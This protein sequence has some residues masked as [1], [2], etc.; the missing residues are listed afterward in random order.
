MKKRKDAWT[1]AEDKKLSILVQDS[2]RKGY[3]KSQAFQDASTLV[4]RTPAACR[5]RWN[6]ILKVKTEPAK[7]QAAKSLPATHEPAQEMTLS[8]DNIIDFLKTIKAASNEG[9]LQTENMQLQ[10]EKHQLVKKQ[11]QLLEKV[12]LREEAF[13]QLQADYKKL[14]LS[15]QEVT[16]GL[17]PTEEQP[18]NKLLH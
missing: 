8:F 18:E 5:Y 11:K 2:V 16:G 3:S 1:E 6:N 14:V 15:I 9:S 17:Y 10:E 4:G 7:M 13:L 12:R